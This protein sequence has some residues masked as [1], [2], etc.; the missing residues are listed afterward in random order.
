MRT[1]ET[2]VYTINDHP[3]KDLCFEWMRNNQPDLNNHNLEEIVASLKAL[4][5]VVGGDMDYTIGQYP[6]GNDFI[7]WTGYDKDAFVTSHPAARLSHLHRKLALILDA[8]AT[9]PA[10][11]QTHL[12]PADECFSRS[13]WSSRYPHLVVQ[14]VRTV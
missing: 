3:D 4:K 11:F 12:W 10:V 5:K 7:S 8:L 6:D 14:K 13:S 9:T 1:I 2:I